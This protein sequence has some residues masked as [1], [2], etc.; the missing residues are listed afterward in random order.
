M[1]HPTL[2]PY[3]IDLLRDEARE[4]IQ[5]GSLGRQQPIYSLCRFIPAREGVG[6]EDEL[7]RNDFLLR[8]RLADLLG[9][10]DWEND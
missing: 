1:L 4:L 8:D 3:S 10:E 2:H 7:E 9:R 6:L 5:C